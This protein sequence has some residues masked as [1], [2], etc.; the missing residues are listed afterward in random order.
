MEMNV[1]EIVESLEY[2]K[3]FSGKTVVVKLGGELLDEKHAA[4]IAQDL[5]LMKSLKIDV[6]IVHGGGKKLSE[7]MEKLGKKPVFVDGKRVTDDQTL[8]LAEMVFVG[9]SK[10]RL[11]QSLVAIGEK[12]VGLSGRDAGF[13]VA[14]K[15]QGL[16]NVGKVEKI[17]CELP[18]LLLC[19]G[20]MP[21]ISSL[22]YSKSDGVLNL[23]ADEL[24]VSV[25]KA[26]GAEKLVFLTQVDGVLDASGKLVSQLSE[27]DAKKMIAEKVVDGGMI[28]KV[29]SAL[30]AVASGVKRVHII[31]GT[32]PHALLAELFSEKGIGTMMVK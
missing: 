3:L 14:R 28:P 4:G 8:E 5:A 21:I 31:N 18:K 25:A 10:S 13:I 27:K 29:E 17:S 7:L 2:A 22:G 12:P 9:N 6:V 15:I 23:N 16:G 11:V 1:Q 20:F 24:A 26:L 30:D 32:K 19:N